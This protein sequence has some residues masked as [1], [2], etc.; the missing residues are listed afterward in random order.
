MADIIGITKH[1]GGMDMEKTQSPIPQPLGILDAHAV[2]SQELASLCGRWRSLP[3][4]ASAVPP[5]GWTQPD[6][7]DKLWRRTPVPGTWP[8]PPDMPA[9][10]SVLYRRSFSLTRDQGSQQIILRLDA[11][12]GCAAVWVNGN[13]VGQCQGPHRIWEFDITDAVLPERNMVCLQLTPMPGNTAA[14][15][16]GPVYLY[17]LPRRAITD[18]QVQV[19][20]PDDQPQLL[21][22]VRA[23]NAQGFTARIALMDGNQ[24]LGY[25]EGRV[26]EGQA[27]AVLPC[28]GV[29][30]WSAVQPRCYRVAV[31]LWDGIAVHHSREI[32][33]GFRR[34]NCRE[35]RFLVNGMPEKLFG[36]SYRPGED[37][38]QLE[39]DLTQIRD[40]NFNTILLEHGAPPALYDLCDQLGLYVLETGAPGS[41]WEA[42]ALQ[43]SGHPCVLAWDLPDHPWAR[44]IREFSQQ[45]DG[46][47]PVLLR[48][49]ALN[50]DTL[51][52]QAAQIRQTPAMA[53]G[54]FGPYA[55]LAGNGPLLGQIKA[56]LQPARFD[57]RSQRLSIENLSTFC[58][59]SDYDCR[60]E[61]RRDGEIMLTRS[62]EL[63]AP[64]GKLAGIT[65]E[66]QYDI[67][68]AGRYHLSAQ[69]LR[70]GTDLI[71]ASGQW[72]VANLK[73]FYDENPGGTIREENGGVCLRAQD[74]SFRIDRATGCLTQ[75]QLGEANL[76]LEEA[77]PVYAEPGGA[78]P[79][80]RKGDD[81]QK[82]SQRKKKPKPSVFE[83][84]H[85]TR[86]VTA[87]FH[88]A[89]GLM[90]TYR[91]HSD[92]SLALELRLRT[93]RTAP[94]K[95][96]LKFVLPPQL[97]CLRWF[98]G[99]PEDA[100]P[101]PS[102]G[103]WMGIHSQT[104]SGPTGPKEP[105][106]TL[107]LTDPSGLGLHIR[108][109]SGLR[110]ALASA[111]DG[112]TLELGLPAGTLSPHTTYQFSFVLSPI[113]IEK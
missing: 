64:P 26:E 13:R 106:Y 104:V 92:G 91:L 60:Y 16:T 72:E 44:C 37:A 83:V 9:P 49:D 5:E 77:Y 57:Y 46:P 79:V 6:F 84:D 75:I 32:S 81:W 47:G 10:A 87:S 69:L 19:T 38:E 14:G 66:T 113:Q 25:G 45:P 67:Y 22:T 95:L 4:D 65:L 82:L 109:E 51:A 34:P 40:H 29:G 23:Q 56:I 98:G 28:P 50:P 35:G 20:W 68:K 18:V 21:V 99:G 53:G 89:S 7:E 71:I 62:L 33:L 11:L 17:S 41:D 97:T 36:L 61:L 74:S 76:L 12:D 15:I 80:L 30:L 55:A 94:D 54:I 85:L 90:Q 1:F 100:T 78:R 59:L 107:T 42:L 24:I 112:I 43:H 70:K 73:H 27:G 105:V 86:A 102:A 63:Q 111:G 52:A 31:I 58:N 39:Q 96:A 93:G 8:S 110:A 103:H 101:L 2:F 3:L 108:C 88:L 48:L